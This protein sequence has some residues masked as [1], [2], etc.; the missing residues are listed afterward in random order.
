[1]S[2][3]RR[4]FLYRN[5]PLWDIVAVALLIGV[6][7]SSVTSVVPAF[8]RLARHARKLPQMERSVFHAPGRAFD[9]PDHRLSR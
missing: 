1:M 3:F 6:G 8:R 9:E 4:T 2:A 5:R 7:V